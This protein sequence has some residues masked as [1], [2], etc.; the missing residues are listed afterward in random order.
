MD[1]L[2]WDCPAPND[3]CAERASMTNDSEYDLWELSCC[4]VRDAY[5]RG[6]AALWDRV[7]AHWDSMLP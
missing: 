2:G 6:D 1:I 5:W 4:V 7:L 3:D